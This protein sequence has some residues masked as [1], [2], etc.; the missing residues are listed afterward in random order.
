MACR[1]MTA[2]RH[3]RNIV[4][5]VFAACTIWYKPPGGTDGGI[6]GSTRKV[7]TIRPNF[8][9]PNKGADEICVMRKLLLQN[10]MC[11]KQPLNTAARKF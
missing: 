9:A 11:S 6:A 1:C 8:Y 4:T 5:G 2:D 10:G 3:A 7:H